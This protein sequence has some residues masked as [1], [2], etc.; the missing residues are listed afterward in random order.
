M[1][2]GFFF[3]NQSDRQFPFFLLLFVFFLNA[4]NNVGS[5][6][7]LIKALIASADER[8]TQSKLQNQ[9]QNDVMQIMARPQ[10]ELRA[11]NKNR[12][13]RLFQSHCPSV[14]PSLKFCEHL[15]QRIYFHEGESSASRA[16]LGQICRYFS[17]KGNQ[18]CT[19]QFLVFL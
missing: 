1:K 9:T 15:R 11:F 14:V 6:Y 17:Q 19:I 16:I 12:C 2:I 4:R 18:S 8:G 7:S 5:I 3:F 13:L 10:Q